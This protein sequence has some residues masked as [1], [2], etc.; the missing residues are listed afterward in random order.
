MKICC[1]SDTHGM[2]RAVKI[3]SCDLLIHAGDITNIG[4]LEQ[5]EDFN[6]WI[7][8]LG[9][10]TIAIPGN[11]D[12]SIPVYH[13]AREILTNCNL[14]IDSEVIFN[15]LKIYGSPWT[16]AF[17]YNWAYNRERGT[18]ISKAWEAIPDDTDILITHGPP[19]GILDYVPRTNNYQGCKDLLKRVAEIRPKLHIFGHLHNNHGGKRLDI[20]ERPNGVFKPQ[21]G[22]NTRFINATT[23]NE[24]YE[25]INSP[26][27]VELD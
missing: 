22:I 2:H 12:R 3:P 10:S 17:G 5:L 21:A 20:K 24:A 25:P 13:E 1:I 6:N 23:C 14:L 15:N 4:E 16:P 7:A 27:I 11:H 9:I 18:D 26:I 8:E 19:F